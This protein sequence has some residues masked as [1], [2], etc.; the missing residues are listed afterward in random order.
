MSISFP[1]IFFFLILFS[2][3]SKRSHSQDFQYYCPPCPTDCHKERYENP[4]KCPTCD[5]ELIKRTTASFDGYKKQSVKIRSGDIILNA[6]YYTQK[7]KSRS[8][9]SIVI[10]HG[11]APTT[12]DDLAFYTTIATNLGMS[13]LAFDKR[14]CGES[15]GEYENFSVVGSKEWFNLLAQ[16]VSACLNWLKSQ[17]EID[18]KKIGL[19]GGSQA[20]W[21]MPLAASQD[22][23]VNFIIIGEGVSVSAGEEQFHSELTGDGTGKGISISEADQKLKTFDGEL[24]Y[25]PRPILKNLTTK[26]LWFFGTND[27]VIPVNASVEVLNEMNNENFSIIMLSN[28]DHNFRNTET[29]EQYNLTEFIEPWLKQIGILE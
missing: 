13:V 18:P 21:I 8:R 9:A 25:N 20:G 2:F 4:G 5:M 26:A 7:E 11:S 12:Y 17:P 16:D 3:I 27:D 22:S 23:L 19:L 29:G 15:E 6:A 14:G 1:K 28:G 24:G 10:A